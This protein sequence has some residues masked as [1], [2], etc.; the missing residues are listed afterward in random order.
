[1]MKNRFQ[2]INVIATFFGIVISI[3]AIS[4]QSKNDIQKLNNAL[5]FDLFMNYEITEK[6]GNLATIID[7]FPNMDFSEY[8]SI[9]INSNLGGENEVTN[10]IFNDKGNMVSMSYEVND[11]IYR[12]EFVYDGTQLSGVNIA[13]KLKIRFSY[14]TKG[15]LLT[16]SREKGGGTLEYNFEYLESENKANIKLIVILEG[17]RRPDSP[18][19]FRCFKNSYFNIIFRNA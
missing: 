2:L 5:I 9:N 15:R 14:D 7:Y 10:F 11:K 18:I 16:I 12:Y 8:K 4:A 17:K 6:N 1:M 3:Q 19:M 13:E